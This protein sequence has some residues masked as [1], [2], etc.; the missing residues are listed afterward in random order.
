MSVAMENRWKRR[1]I[2]EAQADEDIRRQREV[3]GRH[4][5]HRK[6]VIALDP[7]PTRREVRRW[8]RLNAGD[9]ETATELAEAAN[10]ALK[11]PQEWLGDETHWAWDEAASAHAS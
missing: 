11:F 8:M 3:L 10:A 5:A 2:A 9:H 1:L 4:H 6:P 7:A